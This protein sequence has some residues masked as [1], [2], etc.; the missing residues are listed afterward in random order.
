[1]E[2]R[3]RQ[4][5][6]SEDGQASWNRS[7]GLVW[8]FLTALVLVVFAQT[9]GYEFVNYDDQEYVYE[10]PAIAA[11]ISLDRIQW[12]F[13]HVHAGNWHPLTSLSHMLDC[14]VYGLR[15]SG[16][17][18]TNVL[19]HLLTTLFLFLA[20]FRLTG[21]FWPSAI[22]AALFAIHP[23]RVESVAWISERKDV[24]SGLFFM[25]TL[26][27][28]AAYARAS[29]FSLGGYVG[30]TVFFALGL[31]CKPTLVTLPCVL[32][33]LDY[34]PL[35]RFG[36]R[37]SVSL[38]VEKIPLFAL[39]AASCAATLLAQGRAVIALH[40]LS[41]GDRLAN[42]FVSYA[43]Y[44]GQMFWP[45][46]LAVVYP[47]PLGGWTVITILMGLTVVLSISVF[48]FLW[49]A[50][51]PFLLIGWLWFLGMLVPMI[52]I[53]QVGMQA[54]ADRYTYLSQIGLYIAV[55]WGAVHLAH[56]WRRMPAV[57]AALSLLV[58]AAFSAT[59]WSQTTTW[60]TSITLWNQALR[61]TSNNYIAQTHLADVLIQQGHLD[62]AIVLLQDA[63]TVSDYPT[64]HYNLGYAL[65]KKGDWEAAINSFRAAIRTRPNYSQAHSNLGVSLSKLGETDDAITEFREALRIEPN[66]RDAHNNLAIL[67]VQL[68]RRDEAVA[69][70]REALRLK[71]DDVAVKNYLRELGAEE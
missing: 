30:V 11:G 48:A 44:V 67:L 52:G 58:V 38:L 71:P 39:S 28:Y 41:F 10:N 6:P 51:Y 12:A 27:A 62:R 14:S 65:A 42:A 56:R 15:P 64:A 61:N 70:F 68:G 63:L 35:Q 19:L 49:R 8:L 16:H 1:M 32:L 43:T 57:W 34:W 54:R 4:R 13:T 66:Y 25:L 23:L 29:K 33:L 40:Q 59:A 22:V 26:W 31:M 55:V 53:I 17:H 2:G 60:R 46:N 24:L 37:S 7:I 3:A 45:S 69:E 20:L 18:L 50:R 47:Y 5:K 21:S 9:I 36:A